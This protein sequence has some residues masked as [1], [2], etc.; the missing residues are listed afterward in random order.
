M[1]VE[2]FDLTGKLA[3][4]TGS[5]RGLGNA[6]IRGLARAGANV[7]VHGRSLERA[8]DEAA[9]IAEDTGVLAHAVS[10][11]VTDVDDTNRAINEI[12]ENIGVPDILVNN[13]GMQSRAPFNDFAPENW[14][15]V[16]ATNLSS[17]FYVSQP[18]TRAMAERGSGKV[19]N[20]GSVMSM[21]ARQTIAPYSAS[22]GGI[23][24][25]SRGMAADLA[26]PRTPGPGVPGA[27]LRGRAAAAGLAG[28]GYSRPAALVLRPGRPHL[29]TVL[30]IARTPSRRLADLR[31]AAGPRALIAR[32]PCNSSTSRPP[33]PR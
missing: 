32:S 10:F 26:P 20:I 4:V 25:L 18:V 19:I 12:L 2:L 22:K 15:A 13:A 3:L 23:A 17:A 9:K 21:L 30:G 33:T 5:T 8:T 14:N 27:A 11:D 29:F 7:I 24:M 1:S 31:D 28:G 6:L 16:I